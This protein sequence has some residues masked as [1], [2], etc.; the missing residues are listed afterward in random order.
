MHNANEIERTIGVLGSDK[1]GGWIVLPSAP[2]AANIPRD[3]VPA[4]YPFGVHAKLGGLVA[5]GVELNVL[6]RRAA[7]LRRSH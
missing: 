6:F 1:G 2:I 3:R 5:C 7:V 4:V